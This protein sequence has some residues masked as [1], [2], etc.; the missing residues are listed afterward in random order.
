MSEG[1]ILFLYFSALFFWIFLYLERGC[2]LFHRREWNI[3]PT[4]RAICSA[5]VQ[6]GG[7]SSS[8]L[9]NTSAPAFVEIDEYE[10][11][12]EYMARIDE[13]IL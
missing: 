8:G 12:I 7:P 5:D 13:G 2:A 9:L 4:S 3:T 1:H 6:R 11:G 10:F